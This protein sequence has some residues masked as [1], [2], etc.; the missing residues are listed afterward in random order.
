MPLNLKQDVAKQIP[1]I[2]KKNLSYADYAKKVFSGI[3]C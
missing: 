3:I 1:M 2:K